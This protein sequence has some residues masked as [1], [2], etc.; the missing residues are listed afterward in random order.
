MF[1]LWV[2]LSSSKLNDVC[3]DPPSDLL[4]SQYVFWSKKT[5]NSPSAQLMETTPSHPRDPFSYLLRSLR[6]TGP[7]PGTLHNSVSVLTVPE[8]R[9]DWIPGRV[10][11]FAKTSKGVGTFG[12]SLI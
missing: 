11:L 4:D 8:V 7:D 2:T 12:R 6:T 9:Y 10:W 5:R 3:M 1:R